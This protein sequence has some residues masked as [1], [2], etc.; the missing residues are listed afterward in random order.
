MV[1]DGLNW[2]LEWQCLELIHYLDDF[3]VF[4]A[5]EAV[6]TE[7]QRAHDRVLKLCGE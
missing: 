7:G 3:L 2:V 4:E 6:S 5:S 1:A